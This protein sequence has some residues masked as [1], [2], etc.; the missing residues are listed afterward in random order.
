MNR[1]PGEQLTATAT[2]GVRVT[3]AGQAVRMGIQIASIIVLAR[4]LTPEDYGVMAMA[5]VVV[6]FAEV[7]RDFGLASAAVQARSL[8][9][10]QRSNLFWANAAIGTALTSAF[11]AAAPLVSN[12]FD[13]PRLT[14]LCQLLSLTFLLNGMTTQY[15]ADLARRLRFRASVVVNVGS[16]AVGLCCGVVAA[17]MGAGH[18]ALGLVSVSSS[19]AA[20]MLARSLCDWWPGRPRR[21]IPM[22]GFFRFGGGMLGAQLL[23]AASYQAH[24]VVL[25]TTL[26][27]AQLGSYSRAYQLIHLPLNQLQAPATRV[28]LPVL[29]RVQDESLRFLTA[30]RR[31]QSALL[32]VTAL[33]VLAPAA[34]A[35][36]LLPMLLGDQWS[37]ISTPFRILA[38]AGVANMGAYVCYWVYLAKGLTGS[39]FRFS[40]WARPCVILAVVLGGSGGVIGVAT[41]FSAASLV[42]WPLNYW[43]LARTASLPV[44]GLF[45]NAVRV[46][47]AHGFV[48]VAAAGVLAST[49]GPDIVRLG[50]GMATLLAGYA[51]VLAI[52]TSVRADLASLWDI[53]ASRRQRGG[54]RTAPSGPSHESREDEVSPCS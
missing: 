37:G 3:A 32:H 42:L 21:G 34:L 52:S 9:R 39:Y 46:V 53:A 1:D 43:W 18:L 11:L 8:S 10:E 2:R 16:Q 47:S 12:V 36:A 5:M 20:L 17:L 25:G 28:A 15:V 7:V 22:R 24:S 14:G 33:V 40:L 50:M 26:G 6:I 54:V 51:L 13:E 31:G 45:R 23:G 4:L 19:A 30:I 48:A 38:V 49:G 27:A 29:A 44:W 35:P 41:A